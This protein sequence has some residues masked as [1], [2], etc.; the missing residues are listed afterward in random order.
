MIAKQISHFLKGMAMGAAN[1]IPGVSGGTI[2]LI[3]GIFE[4]LINSIKSFDAKALR[5]IMKGD[6]PGFVRKTD[7]FF[8]LIVLLGAVLSVLSLARILGYLFDFYPIFIWSYFF[9]LIVASVFFVGKTVERYTIPVLLVFVLGATVAASL[10]LLSPASGNDHFFY[11]FLCG[12]AAMCSMILPGLSGSFILIL[13]GNYELIMINAV[14]ELDLTI[15][16]PVALGAGA[17]L[18][19]FSHLLSWVYQRYKNETISLLTG[20]IAGSLLILWPWKNVHYRVDQSGEMLLRGGDPVVQQYVPFLP[21]HLTPEVLA[22]LLFMLLGV[23][24]IW[25][26]EKMTA[27]WAPK[28]A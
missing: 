7:L 1:V 8:L 14:N 23:L 11:L 3:T 5:L 16:F 20:F 25:G 19:F 26:L 17:G 21:N 10:S 18:L 6:L 9:G 4:R 13:M 24:T 22:A 15:L 27:L 12:V 28:A 2:A